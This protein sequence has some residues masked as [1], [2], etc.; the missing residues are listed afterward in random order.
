VGIAVARQRQTDLGKVSL[1]S[2]RQAE[3][4]ASET[5]PES[6]RPETSTFPGAG[7]PSAYTYPMPWAYPAPYLFPPDYLYLQ[8]QLLMLHQAAQQK[9]YLPPPGFP[10]G[11]PLHL[12]LAHHP[13]P[14]H[15]PFPEPASLPVRSAEESPKPFNVSLSTDD[16][17]FEMSTESNNNLTKEA[18]VTGDSGLCSDGN[19]DSSHKDDRPEL[20]R[21]APSPRE[22]LSVENISEEVRES[23]DGQGD[24]CGPVEAVAE[25][26]SVIKEEEGDIGE[27]LLLLTEGI[28]CME[29]LGQMKS[30]VD[31]LGEMKLKTMRHLSVDSY[32][33][34][35]YDSLQLLCDVASSVQKG[36]VGPRGVRSKSLDV[37]SQRRIA[38]LGDVSR[39]HKSPRAEQDVKE[40]I[41]KKT[42]SYQRDQSSKEDLTTKAGLKPRVLGSWSSD[43]SDMEA[44]EID[45]RIR[46]AE[47]QR[48]YTEITRKLKRLQSLK[49]KKCDSPK[50]AESP[51]KKDTPKKVEPVTKLDSFGKSASPDKHEPAGQRKSEQKLG[52]HG[53]AKSG[54]DDHQILPAVDSNIPESVSPVRD[55]T[56]PGVSEDICISQKPIID[57][58][59]S[60]TDAFHKFKKAYNAKK[61][62]G[63]VEASVAKSA[64]QKRLPSSDVTRKPSNLAPFSKWAK[65]TAA[66][67]SLTSIKLEASSPEPPILIKQ[68]PA[69]EDTGGQ[70][71]QLPTYVNR[72]IK[73][74]PVLTE[75]GTSSVVSKRNSDDTPTSKPL[76]GRDVVP[77]PRKKPKLEKFV[78]S[79]VIKS[80]RKKSTDEE[81]CWKEKKKEKRKLSCEETKKTW[82]V[83]SSFDWDN[84]SDKTHQ[85]K[86]DVVLTQSH[87]KKGIKSELVDK[88]TKLGKSDKRIEIDEEAN[89]AEEE[90]EETCVPIKAERVGGSKTHKH[91]KEKKH[92]KDHHRD[93]E[94]PA[95]REE[96]R[97]RKKEKRIKKEQEEQIKVKHEMVDAFDIKKEPG[98]EVSQNCVLSGEDL[99][100]GLRILKRVGAHFY[101]GRVT[102]ISPPDIY[103]ILVDKERGNKPHIASREQCIL[104]CV[105]DLRPETVSELPIGARVCAYWSSKIPYLHPGTVAAP[106]IDSNYVIVELDDGDSRD[107]HIKDIRYL[108]ANYPLVD[109]EEDQIACLLGGRRR[110]NPSS[111]NSSPVK[112]KKARK[113]SGNSKG[114]SEEW[115]VSV[116]ELPSSSLSN[117]SSKASPSLPDLSQLP[118]V[119]IEAERDDD[120]DS[121]FVSNGAGGDCD[122]DFEEVDKPNQ[123]RVSGSEKSKIAAFLPPRHLL[124]SWADVGKKLTPKARKLFHQAIS[125]EEE[126]ISV[127]DCAV[128]LSTGRP[129][130]PYIGR[131]QSM[132]ESWAGHMKVQ[133]K[134]FYH[135]AETEGTAKGGGRVEDIK[136]PGALFES[137]HYDE[138]DVQTISHKCEVVEYDELLRRDA[139]TEEEQVYYLAGQYDPVVGSIVFSPHLFK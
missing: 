126:T 81:K 9:D 97:R 84:E 57:K 26:E 95:D 124:W 137:S 23:S 51:R 129:D 72:P 62:T 54:L 77:L 103:G 41:S 99:K 70:D 120:Q 59:S 16:S 36:E 83:V 3:N 131:I 112:S 49:S 88:K 130:R 65:A 14:L 87:I 5:K 98:L 27:G 119:K 113:S 45:I 102:E 86:L 11:Y 73:K 105:L 106:D 91:K 52:K 135:A 122:S 136:T 33:H 110:S 125:K 44:W 47:K 34:K 79:D 6:A 20:L 17:G 30:A 67:P 128:F 78:V 114:R 71:Q 31:C 93:S 39:N 111:A 1:P 19:G 94:N 43:P 66:S 64:P 40:F 139:D 104:E 82:K 53:A 46:M 48:R 13:L 101:P 55:K 138:N 133:V 12:N 35:K 74:E 69:D 42:S 117:N 90:E 89:G 32:H 38:E 25:G 107:I 10:A 92:K 132:W 121:A 68:E 4:V 22:A 24:E 100:D 61:S 37:E 116:T 8:Q 2:Q 118:G 28:E 134:W 75:V 60:F 108:P 115:S 50:K 29:E 96:R 123:R 58:A 63:D 7:Y 109:R 80:P 76:D 21:C 56:S 15:Y 18:S 85:K 127:G